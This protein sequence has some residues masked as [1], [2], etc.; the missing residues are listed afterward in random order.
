[1][2]NSRAALTNLE[3]A[4]QLNPNEP[5]VYVLLGAVYQSLGRKKDAIEAFEFYLKMAPT[6]RFA[7]E[8]RNIITGLKAQ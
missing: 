1:M 5:K 2:N 6:G 8:L 4:R 3:K 7:R